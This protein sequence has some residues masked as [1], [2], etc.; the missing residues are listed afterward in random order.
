MTNLKLLAIAALSLAACVDSPD[1]AGAPAEARPT[2]AAT[3]TR[4]APADP[5]TNICQLLPADGPCSLAC[6][7][8]ALAEQYIA[9][10]TCADFQCTLTDGQVIRAGGCR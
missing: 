3:V 8:A 9:V 2:A 6:D 10:N 1:P 4:I 5:G 7:P